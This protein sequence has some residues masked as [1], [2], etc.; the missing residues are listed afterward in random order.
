MWFMVWKI[1]LE[2]RSY[3]LLKNS[4]PTFVYSHLIVAY[5]FPMP[6]T[7]HVV[8]GSLSTSELFTKV[9][10]F[11]HKGLAYQGD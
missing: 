5:K 7:T 10:G 3:Y 4:C 2:N 11:I 6:P 8:R 1:A 9:L